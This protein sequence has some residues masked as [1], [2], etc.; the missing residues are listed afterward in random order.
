MLNAT[1]IFFFIN[2][3]F[4]F[5]VE[6]PS[7]KKN[8]TIKTITIEKLF[9]TYV[10]KEFSTMEPSRII[11]EEKNTCI[12]YVTKYRCAWLHFLVLNRYKIGQM[13]Q[14]AFASV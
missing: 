5:A 3:V 14:N 10:L 4:V 1:I 13:K 7:K 12:E 8:P 2:I 11:K 6:I 9:Y